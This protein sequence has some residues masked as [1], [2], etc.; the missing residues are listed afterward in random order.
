[1][2]SGIGERRRKWGLLGVGWDGIEEGFGPAWV[3]KLFLYIS[4]S[5]TINYY[6]LLLLL[7]NT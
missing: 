4:I 5:I 7:K 2:R 3:R 6:I 1:L